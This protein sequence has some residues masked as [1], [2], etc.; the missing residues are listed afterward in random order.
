MNSYIQ[1]D[2]FRRAQKAEEIPSLFSVWK[3]LK[4]FVFGDN[5]IRFSN[6]LN[7]G[8]RRSLFCSKCNGK[9]ILCNVFL[10]NRSPD[11]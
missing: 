7:L 2:D 4:T 10:C 3:V 11:V 8:S 6:R 5:K 9:C 1:L